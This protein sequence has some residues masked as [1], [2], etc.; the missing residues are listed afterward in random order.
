MRRRQFLKTTVPFAFTAGCLPLW[1]REPK[2]HFVSVV[3]FTDSGER[4]GK[5]KVEK[6]Q[7]TDEEWKKQLTPEQFEVTRHGATE[8]AFTGKSWNNHER[9]LYKCICCGNA[10]F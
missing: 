9:G 6:I 7:K 3:E 5:V 10:L 2:L 1:A 4:K 8:R